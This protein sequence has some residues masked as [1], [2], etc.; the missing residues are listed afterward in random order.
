MKR[1]YAV[2]VAQVFFATLPLW[3]IYRSFFHSRF[4]IGPLAVEEIWLLAS[5]L[6][7]LFAG[8]A[9]ALKKG[10][11]RALTAAAVSLAILLIYTLIHAR[12]AAGFDPSILPGAAPSFAVECYYVLRL[13]LAPFAILAG[14]FLLD[15]RPSELMPAVK[16]AVGILA[17]VV[18]VCCL[19]GTGFATYQDGNTKILGGFFTW[20]ARSG[21]DDPARYTSKGLFSS[22]NEVGAVLFFL[23]PLLCRDALAKNRKWTDLLLVFLTGFAAVALG[24]RVGALGTLLMIV[25]TLL[26]VLANALRQKGFRACLRRAVP[27]VLLFAVLLGVYVLSP[28]RALQTRRAETASAE[29]TP[30]ALVPAEDEKL[31]A[32][33]KD[34]GWEH[35]INKWFPEIYPAENDT[36]FWRRVLTRDG[37]LNRDDRTF[38]EALIARVSERDGRGGDLWLGIGRTSGVPYSERDLSFQVQVYG[39][40]GAILLLL[41]FAAA[42]IRAGI[43]ACQNLIARRDLTRPAALCLSLIAAFGAAYFA[44]HVFD[45]T[46]PTYA[47]IAPAGMAFALR[48]EGK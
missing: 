35:Y 19:T 21:S 44:G 47:L 41:P 45:S 1:R 6:A 12:H 20:L 3:E 17:G 16:L 36:D 39:I 29:R 33:V 25:L 4:E 42:G 15:I 2:T 30:A 27:Y 23:S 31:P 14:L 18:C 38:K 9:Y 37:K 24:T 22:G 5:G 48:A 28:G 32:Y 40:I 13:Y 10:R 34:H 43:K 7:I 26:A 8:A 46:L 11:K